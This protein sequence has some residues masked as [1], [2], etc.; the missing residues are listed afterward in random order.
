MRWSR[1]TKMHVDAISKR[2]LKKVKERGEI[3]LW[4]LMLEEEVS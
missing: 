1:W 2:R 3:E 4:V